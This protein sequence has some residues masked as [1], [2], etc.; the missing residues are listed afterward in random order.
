MNSISKPYPKSKN[1]GLRYPIRIRDHSLSC[2]LA[3]RIGSVY[4][5][6]RG[7]ICGCF[8]LCQTQLVEVV[9]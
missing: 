4:F 3:Y 9:M 6:S 5:A 7:E 1:D 2:T 8:A